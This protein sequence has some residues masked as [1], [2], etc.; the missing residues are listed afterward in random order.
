MLSESA[1]KRN[2]IHQTPFSLVS[3]SLMSWPGHYYAEVGL[4][5]KF[6]PSYLVWH[7]QAYAAYS[8]DPNGYGAVFA[9]YDLG[10]SYLEPAYAQVATYLTSGTTWECTRV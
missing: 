1:I 8:E 4:D 5:V 9:W 10:I 7:T 2:W 3:N 6:I